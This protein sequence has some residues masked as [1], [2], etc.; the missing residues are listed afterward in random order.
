MAPPNKPMHPTADTL[1]VGFQ[2]RG[3]APLMP[4]A[5]RFTAEARAANGSVNIA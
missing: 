2:Q 5:G 4:G 3:Y 1:L